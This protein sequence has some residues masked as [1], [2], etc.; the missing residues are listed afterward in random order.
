M[1]IL[2]LVFIAAHTAAAEALSLRAEFLAM[3]SSSTLSAST[4]SAACP[5]SIGDYLAEFHGT[6]DTFLVWEREVRKLRVT[7]DLDDNSTKLLI[8]AKV[9]GKAAIWLHSKAEFIELDAESLLDEMRKMFEHRPGRFALRRKF[10]ER[11]WKV[12]EAYREYHHDKIVLGNRLSLEEEELV[13]YVIEGIPNMRL[14]DHARMQRFKSLN[15][16]LEAFENITLQTDG[17]KNILSS[18]KSK[19][20]TDRKETSD[21]QSASAKCYNCNQEGHLSASCPKPKREK[22]SCFNCGKM[23]HRLKNC[24]TK[25]ESKQRSKE[26]NSASGAS[27]TM[28][29]VEKSAVEH[30]RKPLTNPTREY[31]VLFTRSSE[32]E[33]YLLLEAL[34]DSGCAINIMSENAYLNYFNDE[35]LTQNESVANYGGINKSPLCIIGTITAKIRLHLLP[36]HI[37]SIEFA[38]VPDST[39][40]YD[41]L[42]G[43]EFIRMPGISVTLDKSLRIA[44][45]YIME[46]ILNIEAIEQASPLSAVSDNLDVS[47]PH[48][49][50]ER[51]LSLLNT[52][53]CSTGKIEELPYKFEIQ[54]TDENKSFYF[55][56]R[57]LSWHE[58]EE[59]RNIINGLLQREIIRPSNSNFCSPIVLVKKKDG[60]LDLKDGFHH[61]QVDESSVKFTSFVTPDGQY[62]YLRLPFDL[63][64]APAAFQR[65]INMVLKPLLDAR[66]IQIYLDDIMIATATIEE[67]VTIFEEVLHLLTRYNLELN[68][69]KCRFLKREIEYL[70]Y[71]ISKNGITLNESKVKAIQKFPHPKTVGQLQGFLGLTSYF[72]KFIVN[73]ARIAKP[74]HDLTRKNVPFIFGESELHAFETLREKLSNHPVLALN[75]PRAY[76]EL[77]TDA[78]S[79]GYGAVLLQRQQDG[80]MHP[81]MYYSRRTTATESRYHSYELETLA[82]VYALER[83]RVYLQGISFVVIT[84]CNA[85][86]RNILVI[87]PLSFDEVLV[88]RQIQDPVIRKIQK[89]LEISECS[90][91]ELR[92]GIVFRKH[93]N[94][95]LFYVPDAMTQEV[96]RTCHDEYVVIYPVKS[97]ATKEVIACLKE[98]FRHF[99]VCKRIVSDRGSSLVS[100]EFVN[101]LKPLN[102]QH[103]KV[104]T[105]CPQSNGQVERVNRFLRSI[106]SKLS[107]EGKWTDFVA[108]SQFSLNNTL[109]KTI[110]TTP[111]LLCL[112]AINTVSQMITLESTFILFKT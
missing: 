45:N 107:S 92:N 17:K 54:L 94:E 70:G 43:R 38:I 46:D 58:R 9:K 7:Y 65:C 57:R 32:S 96:I 59:V 2:V 85:L 108:K 5:S 55:T 88:Y 111:S 73:Y 52:H 3:T 71:N 1:P 79:H 51:L 40:T 87:E 19:L 25:K 33:Y 60:S 90:R 95:I 20:G 34:V 41:A 14:R 29:L 15:L 97:T 4:L 104:A 8:G 101:Y 11:K 81:I 75:N 93:D 102:V 68:F 78:S 50:K 86:S 27:N 56:P 12:D 16:L 35:K 47:L 6:E 28:A 100:D 103:V 91:F 77:H 36:D 49:V 82:I 39:T 84:E 112:I 66:K 110:G 99:G 10:E 48:D 69:S 106:L 13:E 80:H 89:E 42:L 72:R 61:I 109:H 67:N 23:D 98:Y 44:H 64:N 26:D 76:T 22:G 53:L 37:L 31:C 21:R 105:A 74:L 62:E 63:A 24:P 30:H 83:F 18:T